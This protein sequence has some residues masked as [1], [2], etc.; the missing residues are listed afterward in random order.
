M[1]RFISF[2]TS[3]RS[4]K[5]AGWPQGAAAVQAP[6]Q[7]SVA[8]SEKGGIRRVIMHVF[9]GCITVSRGATAT[10]VE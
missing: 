4:S 7:H 1:L 9:A 5:V 6:E 10:G 8:E 3:S 2:T